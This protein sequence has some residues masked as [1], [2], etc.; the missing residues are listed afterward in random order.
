MKLRFILTFIIGFSF[1]PSSHGQI[2]PRKGSFGAAMEQVTD[3]VRLTEVYPETTASALKLK[4]GDILTSLNGIIIESLDQAIAQIQKWRAGDSVVVHIKRGS[5]DHVAHGQV[6]GTPLETSSFGTTVYGQVPYQN[7]HLRSILTLPKD[8]DQPPV[9]YFM[10][11]VGCASIDFSFN[12]KS[13]VKL[14][15]DGLVASGL[16]VYRVEKPGMGDSQGTVGCLEM[17]YDDEVE[18]FRQGL[19]AL[20]GK[21]TIDKDQI[22]LFG[23]SLSSTT[24]PILANETD[25]GGI[26]IWGGL[27][28]NWFDYYM[29]LQINQKKL[30]GWSESDIESNYAKLK[31]FYTDYLI[32][33]LSPIEL[34]AKG[35]GQLVERYFRADSTRAGLHHYRY[36]QNLVS[37][38]PLNLY[39]KVRKPVLALAGEHDIHTANSG[40]AKA[41][42]DEVNKNNPG[43]GMWKIVPKTT[44]H[45]FKTPSFEAYNQARRSG[46]IN[47]DFMAEHFNYDIA[48]IIAKWIMSN[49]QN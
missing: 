39:R 16:A 38:E 4:G 28:Q 5:E 20:Q 47:S 23:E 1:Q 34:K 24:A 19:K 21:E 45:Y 26:V 36:F 35:Y 18:A 46:K 13:T 33:G 6:K 31:P 14:L 29:S 42:T 8:V 12:P 30:L 17:T 37:K 2:L 40:W 25:L 7:G 10:Q 44:H 3:Q 22:Y 27:H 32:N 15:I 48:G 11:G 9:V 43:L 49:N 41:I